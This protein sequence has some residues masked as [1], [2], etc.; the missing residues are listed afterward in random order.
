[1]PSITSSDQ[2]RLDYV[3]SGDPAGR[4]VVLLAGFMAAATSW[5]FQTGPLA[6]AGYRVLALDARGQG[7]SEKP[8][9]GYRM[10]RRGKDLADFLEALDLRD[11]ILVGQ[12]MGASTVWSY[13]GLFPSTRVAAVVS[14]D[15]TPR[16]LNSEDWRQGFYGFTRQ[17]LGTHFEH[18]VP[19]TGVG[20]PMMKRGMR[21][22]RLV[23]AAKIRPG[24]AKNVPLDANEIALLNDHALQDWRDVI[25]GLAVPALMVA[26]AESEFW[27][28]EHAAASAA[29]NPLVETAVI[30]NAGHA[31]NIEQHRDFNRVL[32]AFAA[33][34][35][36]RGIR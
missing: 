36:A 21:L 28:A 18:G 35:P 29:L 3:E 9:H 10:A 4:P 17:T 30:E 6:S 23:R 7:T 13:L 2:V 12:S 22:V 15:Q 20:T 25:A 11:V 24:S 34:V 8:D 26:G 16:M 33:R 14:I 31:T 27:P 1:M 5:M 32:L 19:D